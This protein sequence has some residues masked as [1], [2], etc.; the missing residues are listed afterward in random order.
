MTSYTFCTQICMQQ[1]MPLAYTS[2]YK[3]R[4]KSG[5]NCPVTMTS[6][7]NIVSTDC[8]SAFVQMFFRVS[9]CKIFV[10]TYVWLQSVCL[11][12]NLSGSLI[13]SDLAVWIWVICF[14]PFFFPPFSPENSPKSWS[15]VDQVSVD[16]PRVIFAKISSVHVPIQS[17]FYRPRFIVSKKVTRLSR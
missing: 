13:S 11:C 14:L 1:V 16:G 9:V 3:M 17:F 6:C 8:V 4:Q 10:L 7:V 2:V 15:T 5:S 12:L